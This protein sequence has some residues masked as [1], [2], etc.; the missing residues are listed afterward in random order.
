[1]HGEYPFAGGDV[2]SSMILD[3]WMNI[4]TK[5]TNDNHVSILFLYKKCLYKFCYV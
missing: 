1:M 2:Q 4:V 3:E 5:K